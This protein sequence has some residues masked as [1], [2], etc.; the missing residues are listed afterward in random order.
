MTSL[1]KI[2]RGSGVPLDQNLH[3]KSRKLVTIPKRQRI[4]RQY[5]PCIQVAK[6]Y[7]KKQVLQPLAIVE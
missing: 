5:R 1:P 4:G 6:L 3:Q 7:A 2:V